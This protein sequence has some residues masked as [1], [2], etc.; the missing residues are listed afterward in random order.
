MRTK[1]LTTKQTQTHRKTMRLQLIL[2]AR[3]L[4]IR[5]CLQSQRGTEKTDRT[6]TL[7]FQPYLLMHRMARGDAKHTLGHGT[8]EKH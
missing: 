1:I 8:W 6:G 7:R 4:S 5:A 3:A 2:L